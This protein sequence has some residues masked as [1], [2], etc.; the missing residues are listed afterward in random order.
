MSEVQ[1]RAAR[2]K[3]TIGR[4][5]GG[6]MLSEQ[7]KAKGKELG[8]GGWGTY[9]IGRGGVLGDV[10]PHVVAAAMAFFPYDRVET[11]WERGRAVLPPAEAATRFAEICHEWATARLADVP[12]LGRL[13]DLLAPVAEAAGVA[14]APLF[15]GWRAMPL[16]DEPAARA[17]QLC[18]VLREHRGA[19]HAIAVLASELTPLEAVLTAGGPGNASFFGWPEPYPDVSHLIGRTGRRAAADALT[20]QLAGTPWLALDESAFAECADLL[21][22][23]A[24]AAFG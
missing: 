9:M 23:A 5:G 3:D 2:V 15:A 16:P 1:A 19:N 21:D 6:F 4:L 22:R 7:A 14:G 20:D 18:H 10:H 11:G 13:A 12:D 8:T 24:K 17:T